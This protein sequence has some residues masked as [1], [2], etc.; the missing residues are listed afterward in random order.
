M[1]RG[2]IS[3]D[4]AARTCNRVWT[5]A[6][7]DPNDP[8]TWYGNGGIMIEMCLLRQISLLGVHGCPIDVSYRFGFG[9]GQETC[10]CGRYQS[11]EQWDNRQA[12]KIYEAFSQIWGQKE[13]RVSR[14]RASINPP[15]LDKAAA[16]D[17]QVAFGLHFDTGFAQQRVAEAKKQRPI[18]K[19]VQGVLYLVDTP[20]E[21][22]AF[23]CVPGMHRQVDNWL[24]TLPDDVRP[25]DMLKLKDESAAQTV[26]LGAKTKRIPA[27]AGD[28]IIWDTRL[29]HSAA[30]NVGDA[31]RVAQ[32]VC[33]LWRFNRQLGCHFLLTHATGAGIS[34]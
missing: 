8:E 5:Y 30:S 11:Q 26:L 23:I 29:P 22:G 27:K 2:V 19:G 28:L 31:P 6:N 4:Q 33:L 10:S 21:N 13:L 34:Q 12:P 3:K 16:L 25:N 15:A 7:Q 18:P 20:A 1:V 32:Y 17:S 14:D 24:E 9:S